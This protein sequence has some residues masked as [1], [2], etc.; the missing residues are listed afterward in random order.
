MC[1]SDIVPSNVAALLADLAELSPETLLADGWDAA[2]IGTA[3][4]KGHLLAVYDREKI[5]QMLVADGLTHEE[6]HEYVDINVCGAW[7]GDGTPIFIE[8]I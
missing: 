2:L 3:D 5:H 8:K 1:G 6:A 4:R 7:V